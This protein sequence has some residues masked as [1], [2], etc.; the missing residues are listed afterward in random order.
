MITERPPVIP[1]EQSESIREQIAGYAEALKKAAP[2]IGQLGLTE[3]EFW[4]AGIFRAAIETDS[5]DSGGIN[6]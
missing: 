5:W 6:A 4:D 1:C 3:Q 2:E